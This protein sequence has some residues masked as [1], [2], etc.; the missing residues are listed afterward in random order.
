MKKFKPHSYFQPASLPEALMKLQEA[1]ANANNESSRR[2]A[3]LDIIH[4]YFSYFGTAGIRA[5]M[6]KLLTGT[7]GNKQM[8][9]WKKGQHGQNL[10][11]FL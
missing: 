8:K 3:A 9:P 2:E 11:L 6:W 10:F 7:L 4:E 5:E 1:L